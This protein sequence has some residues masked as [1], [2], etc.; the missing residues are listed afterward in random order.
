MLL[1]VCLTNS[2]LKRIYA[3]SGLRA[4]PSGKRRK[5]LDTQG[6][7]ANRNGLKKDEAASD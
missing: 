1:K 5:T 6:L 3:A 2:F 7:H 4:E